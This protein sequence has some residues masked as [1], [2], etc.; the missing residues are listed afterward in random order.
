MTILEKDLV[1]GKVYLED[2]H[3]EGWQKFNYQHMSNG[4][5]MGYWIHP[6]EHQYNGTHLY[7]VHLHNLKSLELKGK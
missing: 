1:V 5:A 7:P 2:E 3:N 4:M 6:D